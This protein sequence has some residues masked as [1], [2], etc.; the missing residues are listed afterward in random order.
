MTLSEYL[1][2]K[3][4]KLTDFAAKSGVSASTLS[5]I[6]RG[7]HRPDWPTIDAIERATGGEVGPSDYR[8]ERAAS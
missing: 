5:R 6:A 8:L 7:L 4:I 2:T 1:K 3:G